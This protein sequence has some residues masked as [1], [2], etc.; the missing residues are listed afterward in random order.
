MASPT[1]WTWVWANSGSWWWTGRPGLLQS[2]GSQRVW[3]D[4][5]TEL[6]WW[7]FIYI[8][9]MGRCFVRKDA[10][11]EFP[12][13]DSILLLQRTQVWSLVGE[14]RSHKLNGM[15]KKKKKRKD[16]SKR[17]FQILGYAF[18]CNCQVAIQK[19]FTNFFSHQ[20]MNVLP[21]PNLPIFNI[22][23]SLFF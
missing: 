7:V 6:N 8:M 15:A 22:A 21:S 10:S 12:G 23:L 17:N 14:L 1:Q 4:W 3:D 2:M 13:Q 19:I 16:V 18:S 5:E 9:P 11:W 20:H